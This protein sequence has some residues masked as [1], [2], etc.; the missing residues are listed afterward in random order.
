LRRFDFSGVV[1]PE[2]SMLFS[3]GTSAAVL[4]RVFIPAIAP[5]HFAGKMAGNVAGWLSGRGCGLEIGLNFTPEALD[6]MFPGNFPPPRPHKDSFTMFMRRRNGEMA[7][8][9]YA[10][11]KW[12]F[13]A[14]K[15]WRA[16]FAVNS[17]APVRLTERLASFMP[18]LA[19]AFL[20]FYQIFPSAFRFCQ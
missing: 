13:L 6:F 8:F 11:L 10:R 16:Y 5:R 7:R 4:G 3:S 1:G 17:P 9:F 15:L 14:I 12:A 18:I 20:L 2:K 19:N